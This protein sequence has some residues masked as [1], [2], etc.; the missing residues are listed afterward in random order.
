MPACSRHTDCLERPLSRSFRAL[1]A[2]VGAHPWPFLLLP[3]ALS[4]AL[5]SGFLFVPIHETNDLEEQFTPVN[6]P[7]KNDR[8][9]VQARFPTDDARRFSPQRLT[10]AGTSA[11]LLMVAA[12]GTG[13]LL[14]REAF[15]QLLAL[16]GAVR[17]LR[18]AGGRAFEDLCARSSQGACHSPNPLLGAAQGQAAGIEALLPGLTF[19]LFQGRLFLGFFLGGVTLGPGDG[20]AR[21]LLAAKALR[22]VYYLQEDDAQRREDS[23]RWLDAFLERIPGVLD[24]LNFSSVRVVYFT[25]LSRQKELKN[26]AKDV[27]PLVSVAYFLTIS[28]SIV[29]CARLDCVRTKV[30]VAFFGVLASGLSVISSFGLLLFCGVPFVITAAN[31]P[32]LILGIGIDDM[33]IMVSCWQRTKVKDNIQVRMANTYAEAAVSVTITTL[34]DVLTFYIG[35]AT[36]FPSVQSFCIYTGTAFIFCYFYNLM[37]LG[38]VLALDGRREESNRHWLTFMKVKDEPQD[39]S[40][41]LYNVCCVGGSFD[42]STGAETEHLMNTFFKKYY[43]PF[44]MHTW[45]KVSVIILYLIYLGSSFYGCIQIKEGVNLRNVAT[46]DS[47]I[48]PYYDLKEKYFSEYGPRVMVIVTKSIAYWDPSVRED[49]EHCIDMIGNISYVDKDF[50]ESWLTIYVTFAK[51]MSLNINDRNVF[52]GNLP[53]LFT[54]N[55]EYEQDVKFSATE[56]LASRFF[57]QIVNASTVVDQKKLLTE[58]RVIAEDCKIPLMVY[59]PAFILFDQFLV[60]IKNTIETVII[61]TGAMLI[62]SLLLIPNLLCSL[63]VAFA[64][65]SVIVGVSGF[66]AYWGINLDSVSMINLVICIGFSVDYSAHISYAFVSSKKLETNE[67]AVDA[68]SHLGY[69]ILQAAASTLVGVFVLSMSSAYVFRNCFKIIL[70]VITFG[71]AHGLL[72]IPVFLTLFGFCS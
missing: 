65:V 36:S 27:I 66:M 15:A 52:I 4:A 24:S 34:T 63:W 71:A 54:A 68:V 46:D 51:N 12:G 5:G 37:F 44:I 13:S 1:G 28:F 55:P 22:L 3:L 62:V 25:S 18:T 42:K 17:G 33:F 40:G 23:R 26:L 64:I 14:T 59:H 38:A 30:S 69:P 10:T 19:P 57:I 60:I 6:S 45:A 8:R 29:S 47:Y 20:P 39:S 16:D 58:L 48:I 35:I 67:R 21:P 41:C 9:F 11:T 49:L 32:F 2:L 56:I 53:A 31:S 50:S 43:G 72:F 7:A 61:A 70:L